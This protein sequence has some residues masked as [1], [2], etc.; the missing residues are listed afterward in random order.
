MTTTKTEHDCLEQELRY[1][2]HEWVEDHGL[3]C[4]PFEHWREAWWECPIC[5]ER[6]TAQDLDRMMKETK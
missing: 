4:G 6:F 3:E 2:E 5:G 1:V